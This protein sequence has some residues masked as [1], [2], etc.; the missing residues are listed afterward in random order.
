MATCQT[1]E[2]TKG[3]R[4]MPHAPFFGCTRH[5]GHHRAAGRREFLSRAIAGV[6]LAAFV[7]ALSWSGPAAAQSSG[8]VVLTPLQPF[9][10]IAIEQYPG[11]DLTEAP[12]SCPAVPFLANVASNPAIAGLMLRV[13]WKD[14]QP[15]AGDDSSTQWQITDEAFTQA[16]ESTSISQPRG[17]TGPSA[18]KFV[19]LAFVPGFDTPSWALTG[20]QT[21]SFC[22]P[23]GVGAGTPATLPLPW[24][25]TYQAEWSAFMQQVATHYA[26]KQDLLMIAAAGPT[27]VSDEMSLP[28]AE[29]SAK[30][31]CSATDISN[32]IDTWEGLAP[33]YTPSAYEGAWTTAFGPYA[34]FFPSQYT[35]LSLYPGLPVGNTSTSDRKQRV[36]TPQSVL[37]EG[38]GTFGT[39]FALQANGLT[40][41]SGGTNDAMYQLVGQN[42]AKMVTG[43]QLVESATKDLQHIQEEGGPTLTASDGATALQNALAAGLV[44]KAGV[45]TNVDFLEVYETDAAGTDSA[46][47]AVLEESASQLP[48]P[49]YSPAYTPPPP[50][51]PLC[52]GTTCS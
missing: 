24:D 36:D 10:L 27:S 33:P 8:P 20:V 30:S 9:G 23:Y 22:I 48:L 11:C 52:R 15:T 31:K 7:G 13:A 51:R 2:D 44:S 46:V 4:T 5:N 12:P 41:A 49:Q 3:R 35:S 28:G 6:A 16:E 47:Q 34:T 50:P 21:A 17:E 18:Q 32:D 45:S 25:T 19:V 37:N 42:S 40:Y 43:F 29:A 39:K 1:G 14:M 38:A 26:N